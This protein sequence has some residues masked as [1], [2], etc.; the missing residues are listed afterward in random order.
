MN[1]QEAVIAI[2]KM[3]RFVK[4]LNYWCE[5]KEDINLQVFGDE[6]FLIDSWAKNV[7]EYLKESPATP[8]VG[9][10]EDIGSV[11]HVKEYLA[12]K[13]ENIPARLKKTLNAYII[14]M[15]ALQKDLGLLQ[16]KVKGRYANLPTPL[17]NGKA[18]DLLQR[19]V[20]AGLLRK[21]FQP[22]DETNSQQ[23]KVLAFAVSRLMGFNRTHTYVYFDR[24]WHRVGYTLSSIV[25][26][27]ITRK[28]FQDV[29]DLYPE[30]DFSKLLEITYTGYVFNS[31]FDDELKLKLYRELRYQGYIDQSTTKEQ[32]LGIFDTNSFKKPVNW[33]RT[34]RQLAYFVKLAFGP[35]NNK[36]LWNK[37]MNCFLVNG[38]EPVKACFVTGFSALFR[39]PD[40]DTYEPSLKAIAENY[41]QGER[42]DKPKAQVADI[43]NYSKLNSQE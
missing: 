42:I 31:P 24:L 41:S 21:D 23:L 12:A 14:N 7:H 36:Y 26:S 20:K 38:E 3:N 35:T 15:E 2:T 11:I 29:L 10:I 9:M 34:Q 32:F 13:G 17:A 5:L 39:S 28:N 1:R 37:T 27:T 16:K 18:A 40:F 8:L 25:L 33:I 6:L 43:N 30:V 4:Q 22:Y 19:A